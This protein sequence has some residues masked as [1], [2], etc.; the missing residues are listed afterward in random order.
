MNL[1]KKKQKNKILFFTLFALFI[2]GFSLVLLIGYFSYQRKTRRNSP[3]VNR[4]NE[5]EFMMPFNRFS[6]QSRDQYRRD[7]Q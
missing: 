4:T 1:M 3:R 5:R 2:I 7:D 6:D